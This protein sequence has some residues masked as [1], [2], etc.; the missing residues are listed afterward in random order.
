MMNKTKPPAVM[1]MMLTNEPENTRQHKALK[2]KL[3]EM[4]M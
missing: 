4:L 1:T 2:I 3:V